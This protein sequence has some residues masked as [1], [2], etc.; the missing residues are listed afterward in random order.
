MFLEAGLDI[1]IHFKKSK[2]EDNIDICK[3]IQTKTVIIRYSKKQFN[4]NMNMIDQ[5]NN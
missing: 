5:F 2:F 3:F 1:T 4:F